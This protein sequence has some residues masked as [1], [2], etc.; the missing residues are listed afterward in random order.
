MSADHS[1]L[2]YNASAGSGKTFTLVKSYLSVLLKANTP[3]HFKHIL[4]ITF[5][6]KAAAEMKSRILD[7]LIE[8]SSKDIIENPTALFSQLCKD[9]KLPAKQIHIKSKLVLN[10]ILHNYAS[11]DISTIDGLTHKLIRTFAYDLKLPLNFEVEL[12]TERILHEAVDRLISKAGTEKALTKLLVDF[13]IEKADDD[14]SWDISYDFNKIAKLLTNENDLPYLNSLKNKK[15]DDFKQLKKQV[16]ERVLKAEQSIV[17]KANSVLTLISECGLEYSDFSGGSR[18]YLPNYFLN[19]KNLDL[20]YN[21]DKAWIHNLEEKP[22][23]PEKST[24]DEIKT[25]LDEIKPKLISEF[26]DTR[27]L[28]YLIKFL[29]S[30]YKNITPLSVLHEIQKEVIELKAEENIL[31]ISEFNTL[32]SNEIK[33]QPTPFIYERLGEKFKHYFI[34]EFQDT[35]K[36]QWENLIP[37]LDNALASENGSV[38]L[39]GDAKQ[40]IYRWRGGRAEQFINLYNQNTNPFTVKPEVV[41]LASNFRSFEEIVNFNNGFFKFLSSSVFSNSDYEKLYTSA[42][43]NIEKKHTGFVNLTFLE[44]DSDDD[45]DEKYAMEAYKTILSCLQ[46]GFALKDICILVRKKKE[47]IVIS[48]YLSSYGM[49]IMSTE[50]LLIDNSPKVQFIIN[51]LKLIIQPEN[52]EIKVAMLNFLADEKQIKDKHAFFKSYL[53]SKNNGV[54]QDLGYHF[55]F[56]S[57][58]QL[59]LF[60]L[61]ETLIR[62]FNLIPESDAY[63]QYFMDVVLDFSQK[64]QADINSFL[65]HY[66]SKKTQ[67]SIV[68]PEGFNAVQVMTIHKSKGLEFPVVIFPYA[69]LN[70]Y[71]E[72]EPN[73]WFE[74]DAEVFNSFDYALL[75]YSK[76]F[77]HFG[78]IGEAIFKKHQAE[79]ELDNLNLLYV[80]LTRPIEQLHIISKNDI[81][82]K[83]VVKKDTYSGFFINYL[84]HLGYWEDNK[85][86]YGFGNKKRQGKIVEAESSNLQQLNYISV[87]KESHD[88]KIITNSGYLWDTAQEQAIEKGNLIHLA[89]SFIKTADDIE[90]AFQNLEYEVTLDDNQKEVL[91]RIVNQIV[92]HPKLQQ[93]FYSEDTIYNERDIISNSGQILRPDRLNINSKNDVVILDYKSGNVNS[94]HQ[95][96]LEDYKV[97]ITQMGFNVTKQILVY[98]NDTIEIKEF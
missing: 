98:I 75:N 6:N 87:S 73:E 89:M 48:E 70:I 72:K 31:L 39:V 18:A 64:Q 69:E 52:A 2:I 95:I 77:K 19:L 46:N 24:T 12:D 5:T 35:S 84:K 76:Q 34:D 82:A 60:E 63:V 61:T 88:M 37:L 50:T 3:N 49:A 90:L 79:L 62:K 43:Q 86:S 28:F 4:A 51:T 57:L 7:A 25:I 56:S 85:L 10:E 58:S 96:Q 59:S 74:L 22:L 68:S 71:A 78:S 9:L 54:F 38:M 53:S 30:V 93:Y 80:A 33:E 91:K 45:K 15:R 41:S 44:L 81:N 97:I 83:G 17:Q 67:L 14:K 40:A 27:D 66:E 55:N 92:Q 26:N 42:N 13:A 29:Q 8:F 23:Y 94:K 32:I 20:N 1:F 11:F 21:F 36:L 16:S 65:E 47:G